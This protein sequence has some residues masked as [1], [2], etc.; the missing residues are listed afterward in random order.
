V[1]SYRPDRGDF[2]FLDFSPQAGH[3]QAGRRPALIVSPRIFNTRTG[4]AFACPITSQAK[5]RSLEVPLPEGSPL[6]GVILVDQLRSVDWQARNAQ[7]SGNCPDAV[8]LEALARIEAILLSGL[9]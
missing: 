2:V 1:A 7:Y 6:H 3:E 5:G 9:D 8:L 4:L